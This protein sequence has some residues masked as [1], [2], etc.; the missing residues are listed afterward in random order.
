MSW[1][2]QSVCYLIGTATVG[3]VWLWPFIFGHNGSSESASVFAA[4]ADLCEAIGGPEADDCRTRL[5]PASATVR[6]GRRAMRGRSW[7]G[8]QRRLFLRRKPSSPL[9]PLRRYGLRPSRPCLAVE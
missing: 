1:W 2:E 5:A 3:A 4:A 9:R 8:T 7:P 6:A